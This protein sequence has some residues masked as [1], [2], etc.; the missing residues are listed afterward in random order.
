MKVLLDFDDSPI[1]HF[2]RRIPTVRFWKMWPFH[3][4]LA[5][6][7]GGSFGI[8]KHFIRLENADFLASGH[9]VFE[10]FLGLEVLVS[11][12]LFLRLIVIVLPS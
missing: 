11:V 4:S 5:G 9:G 8:W 10:S 3:G 1:H 12:H 7:V 2:D 6:E